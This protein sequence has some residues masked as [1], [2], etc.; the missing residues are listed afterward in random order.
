MVVLSSAVDGLMQGRDSRSGLRAPLLGWALFCVGAFVGLSWFLWERHELLAGRTFSWGERAWEFG[1]PRAFLGLALLPLLL[2]GLIGSRA[3]LPWPQRFLSL[4]LRSAF[5][6][7]LI[8]GL[9][10]PQESEEVRRICTVALVDVSTSI[11]DEALVTAAR[12]V[13]ELAEARG[14]DDELRVLA[15]AERAQEVELSGAPGAN[16]SLLTVEELRDARLGQ[17]TDVQ[18]AL[19]LAA[20]WTHADCISRYVIMSDGIETRGDAFAALSS[21]RE[22]GVRV[23]TISLTER[24]AA[25]VAVVG[26]EIPEGVRTGEPFELRVR[27]NSTQNSSGRLLLYQGATLNGLDGARELE[28]GPG[29]STQSFKTVVRVPGDVTYR[30]EFVPQ[31][32]D[33]F[34]EN[35]EYRA[36]REV[37]GPPRVLIVDRQRGQAS[38][39]TQ[40]LVAQQF[41]VDLRGPSA[42]PL[43]SAELSPFQFVI[44][45]DLAYSEVSRGAEKLLSSYVRG[46]GALLFAG[47]EAGYGPGGWDRSSLKKILP[48]TMDSRKERELPGVAM[49]LVIDRSGSMTGL[50]MEM[51]KEACRATLGVLQGS[52]LIEVIAFDS[53][54]SR[55]VKMQPARYRARI[56]SSVAR[57]QP[58]GGTEIFNSLDMAYQDLA[59]VEARKKH[60]ILLTDGNAGSDGLYELA[61]AAFAE[62]ITVTAVGLGGG[63]NRSLLSM[64]AE[65]GGGRFHAAEDPSRLPRIFTRETELIS[66]K[67]TLDDWF[68][69]SVVRSA[70]FL[71]GVGIGAAPYLRGYTST[72]LAAPPSELILASDRGEPILARRPVGL[73]WTLAWTSDLKARWATDWLRWGRF[74]TFMAQM[75]R[76]HQLRDDTEIRPMK[77]EVIGEEVLATVEVFDEAENFDNSLSSELQ[78]R[79]IGAGKKGAQEPE[80]AQRVPFQRVA[81]GLIQARAKLPGFGAFALKANHERRSS[82]GE[83]RPAGVS[84]ASVSRPYPE[85][86]RDLRPRVEKLKRWAESGGGKSEPT[87]Q[88]NWAAGEDVVRAEVARQGDFIALSVLLFFLDLFVR[89]VRLFDRDFRRSARREHLAD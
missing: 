74:G 20:A 87:P 81:P 41:D 58:G 56:E 9:G 79:T 23:S 45:S 84:H 26:L 15:F 65:T 24:P 53:R 8:L 52:D 85:E 43:S 10:R 49:A 36:S 16:Q 40:A 42:M 19:N 73:G 37:P 71:K 62:G 39:L 18:A 46:G 68:P 63:V 66:K 28:L 34:A 22:S 30:A 21:V 75:I 1:E 51:A 60:I 32:E 5:F 29:E 27:L 33:L 3:D 78:I 82:S 83:L 64:I 54:P 77:V 11:P 6:F 44:L 67:A 61:S 14:Q 31:S 59:A 25:D 80:D 55:Y 50:P 70:E 86:F 57:I 47:G 76:E 2:W 35:N 88:E 12:R 7:S 72:Q 69:I 38:Y 89:R 4:F 13:S 48:V 17:A